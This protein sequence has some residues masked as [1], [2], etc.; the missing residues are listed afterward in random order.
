M[1]CNSRGILR[2]L[3]MPMEAVR[4]C[5]VRTRLSIPL[6]TPPS[7]VLADTMYDYGC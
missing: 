3:C 1:A 4:A 5:V 7:V 2:L 6:K